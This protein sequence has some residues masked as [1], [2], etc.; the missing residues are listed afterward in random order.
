MLLE[1]KK[2]LVTGA[3]RGIGRAIAVA[4]AREGCDVGINDYELDDAARETVG[5]VQATG[6]RALLLQADVGSAADVQAMMERFVAEFGRIDV[7]VNNAASWRMA[8]FLEI[9]EEDWDRHL[10]VTLK[11]VFLGSQA[12]AR[13]MAG[14]GGG[15]IVSISSVHATR[16]WPD[17]TV[18]GIGKAGVLRLTQSMALDLAEYGIRCNA[19]APGYIDSRLLPPEREHERGHPTYERTAGPHI[20]CRRIGVPDDIAQAVVYLCSPL[21]SYVNG[22]CLL[23]DGGFLT[24]GTPA[25]G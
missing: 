20:P 21:A 18:Y 24:G 10:G 9:T 11:G 14:T 12:A 23:V 4:L 8:P 25:G 5:M 13:E 7:M 17:D 6:R 19:I 1:G 22:T 2:A 15:S 16:A 3:R